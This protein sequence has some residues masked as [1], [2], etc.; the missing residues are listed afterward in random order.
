MKLK[1]VKKTY[2]LSV[3]AVKT[4]QIMRESRIRKAACLVIFNERKKIKP[5]HTAVKVVNTEI[6]GD[7]NTFYFNDFLDLLPK[8]LSF[9]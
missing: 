1:S 9:V 3:G 6:L 5:H 8:E 4:P 7:L 2:L